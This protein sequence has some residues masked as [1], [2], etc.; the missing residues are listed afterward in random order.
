MK[1]AD[2]VMSF[3]AQQGVKHVFLLTGGGAMHLNDALARCGDLTFVCNHHEQASAIAAEN[4]SKATNNLGVALVTT[5]PGGTNAITGVVG[6]WLD[7][8]PMLVISG[9]VKRADRMYR[10][11]GTSLGVRQRGSQEVDIVS[12]VKPITK[13]AVTIEDPQSIRYHLEKAVH[14]A[15][16]G[17]PGPVWIDIPIDVQAAPIE[18]DTMRGFDPAEL[19]QHSQDD[20]ATKVR[21]VLNRL[22]RAERPFIFAGNGVRVSGAA[23]AFE[24]LMRCLNVPVGLTWMA[25]D[26]LDDDDPL[27]VGR[28]GTVASRGANFALQNADFVLVIGTRLDP[29]LMGWDPHQFARG[30]YKT[31]VDIDPAEL[32]KLEGAIDNPIC[33]AARTFIDQMLKQAGSVLDKDKDRSAWIKRC[34]D[35]KARYP[36]VLPEHR[37]PGLVSVY[38]L[39]EIIGQEAG[40]N[41]RVVSGSSGSAIEVFL[42][43]YRAR[44][45]RRV[46]HTAGL[47]AMGYGIPASIGVCL[48]SGKKTICVDGDGG[49]QLNIQE[50]AT[51]AHLQLPI[52]LFVLN[53]QGY[54]SIRA[55]Q[56]NY[57]GCPNIGCSPET[58]VSIPDYRKVARAYGLKTAVI[59]GQGEGQADLRASVRK[60]LRGRGPVLCDVHVIPDEIRAPRVT[61]I[62]RPDGSFLSKPLEDLWPFLDRDEFAQNMIVEPVSE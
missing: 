57:F 16:T 61:S 53:N 31:V 54:A 15:R 50:L 52:K 24:K 18:T 12:L 22:N 49:L 21:D 10:P 30:A 59:E 56:T 46:F 26:L 48:G 2:Y 14:L 47:G 7:S 51:I 25:M 34:Q 33:A 27:F 3:V 40:P 62:Q 60:V 39:A 5:G 8:T 9:Q 55:S 42:L 41:D 13:Y 19:S 38:H 29:P 37:A 32:R 35:W 11:D 20:L 28:P 23:A 44:K 17:R 43:A 4:Y 58:G 45:G 6:A 36:I 1:V